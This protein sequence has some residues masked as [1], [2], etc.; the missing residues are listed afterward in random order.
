M[1][2]E[3]VEAHLARMAGFEENQEIS[4]SIADIHEKGKP[5][6]GPEARLQGK[7]VKW[8]AERGYPCLSIQ[9]RRPIKGEVTPGWPD[10]T[11]VINHSKTIYIELKSARGA[12]REKQATIAQQMVALGHAW[13]QIRSYSGFLEVMGGRK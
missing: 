9:P 11:L 13:Y 8:A 5:D 6:P 3:Q 7:I 10:I 4:R 1:T 2:K 12:L